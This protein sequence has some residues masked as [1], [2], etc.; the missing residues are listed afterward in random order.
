MCARAR[1]RVCDLYLHCCNFSVLNDG[2][3][4]VV[5]FERYVQSLIFDLADLRILF[6]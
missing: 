4:C 2:C 5:S 3:A 6:S 1:V